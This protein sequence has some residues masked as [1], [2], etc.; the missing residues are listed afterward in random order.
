MTP[1]GSSP[2]PRDLLD[3]ILTTGL[4]GTSVAWATPIEVDSLAQGRTSQ[5]TSS[6]E[7]LGHDAAG[8][9]REFR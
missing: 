8:V 5:T 9:G 1:E 7:V 4:P 6:Q 3:V 2:F